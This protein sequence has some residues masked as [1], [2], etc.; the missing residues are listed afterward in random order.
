MAARPR[1]KRRQLETFAYRCA[2]FRRA[3]DLIGEVTRDLMIVAA[4]V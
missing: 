1:G 3:I 2:L 4:S